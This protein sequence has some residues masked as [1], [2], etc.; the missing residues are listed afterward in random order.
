MKRKR[1]S[2][3]GSLTRIMRNTNKAFSD[4]LAETPSFP[5]REKIDWYIAR[6]LANA[7]RRLIEYNEVGWGLRERRLRIAAG[8]RALIDYQHAMKHWR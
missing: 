2:R 8:K 3:I 6:K 5:E 1:K 4:I 7:L